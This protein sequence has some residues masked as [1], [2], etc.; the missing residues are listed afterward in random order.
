MKRMIVLS[1]MALAGCASFTRSQFRMP[2]FTL[3]HVVV[4][5]IG[6]SGGTLGLAIDVHN[7]NS[8]D[9]RGTNLDLSLDVEGTHLGDVEFSDA[10]E[11]AEDTITRMVVPMTFEWT[12]V[13]AGLRAALDYGRVNYEMTGTGNM[14]TPFGMERIPFTIEGE[15][16]INMG[17]SIDRS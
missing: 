12:G 4:R 7:P 8:F 17:V 3:D 9:L 6:L 1:V 16:P 10:F 13:G 5:S 11:L 14:Q 15:V 2:T